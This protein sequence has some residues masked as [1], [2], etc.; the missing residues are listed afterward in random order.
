MYKDLMSDG[1]AMDLEC[2]HRGADEAREG[3]T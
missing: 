2:Q 1:V 3:W